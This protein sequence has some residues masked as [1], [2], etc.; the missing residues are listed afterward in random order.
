M[1]AITITN[2]GGYLEAV[3]DKEDVTVMMI[4]IRWDRRRRGHGTALVNG[5]KDHVRASGLPITG[6]VE[7]MGDTT[8]AQA[9]KF[10]KKQG[11]TFKRG[12]N[13]FYIRGY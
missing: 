8:D 7:G 11:A 2:D 4:S 6:Y 3:E 9:K 5:L 13:R 12:S 1:K 10:W